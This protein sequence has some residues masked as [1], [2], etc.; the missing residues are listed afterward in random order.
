VHPWRVITLWDSQP[1][2][3]LEV[4]ANVWVCILVKNQTRARVLDEDMRKA[5]V[6]SSEV[7]FDSVNHLRTHNK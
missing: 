4:R 7:F 5:D 6:Y 3:R 2:P 1:C